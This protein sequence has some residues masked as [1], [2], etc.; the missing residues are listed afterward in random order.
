[1]VTRTEGDE[2]QGVLAEAVAQARAGGPS[3]EASRRVLRR[4]HALQSVHV[5]RQR[6]RVPGRPV[7][8][9]AACVTLLLAGGVVALW[10]V[11][12]GRHDVVAHGDG[13]AKGQATGETPITS[14]EG[15]V[16][17]QQ[18]GLS[19]QRS[20]TTTNPNFGLDGAVPAGNGQDGT[21]ARG[22]VVAGANPAGP[23]IAF[24]GL[25]AGASPSRPLAVAD[26]ATVLV[27][28]GGDGPIEL[29]AQQQ[30][31]RENRLHVWDWGKEGSQKSRPL[32]SSTTG[33]FA[34]SPDGK[35]IVTGDGKV[36]DIAAGQAAA[37]DNMDGNIRRMAFSHDGKILLLQVGQGDGDAYAKPAVARLLEFPS[38]KKICEIP[39]YWQYTF[40]AAFTPDG[41]QVVLMDKDRFIKRYDVRTG[42]ELAK[43][44]PRHENSIRMI[45]VSADGKLLA[46][47]GTRGDIHLW[48]LATGKHLHQL[49]A[50]QKPDIEGDRLVYSI[51]FSPDGKLLAGGGIHSLLIWDTNTGEVKKIFPRGSWGA[52]RCRFI[53][54]GKKIETVHDFAGTTSQAGENVLIYPRVQQWVLEE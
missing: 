5:P 35:K 7:L 13:S 34:V 25:A 32:E 16:N 1:M 52:V 23:G 3:A 29:G 28:T 37:I 2:L 49:V 53:G 19:G 30:W 48:E 39:D 9:M 51:A 45:S 44:E 33:S 4:A 42:K 20:G 41:G 10:L 8:A 31:S 38:G 22:G 50:R 24:G 12:H 46:S 15:S 6:G 40:A 14:S 17:T 18:R 47:A 43:Y 11:N 21:A 27:S 26:K 54:D 36:I